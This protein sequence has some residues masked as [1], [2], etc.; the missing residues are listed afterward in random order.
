VNKK[1]PPILLRPEWS[2]TG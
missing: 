1:L 2:R